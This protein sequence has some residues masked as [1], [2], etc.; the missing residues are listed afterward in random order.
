[1]RLRVFSVFIEVPSIGLCRIDSIIIIELH[2]VWPVCNLC[3][4]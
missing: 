3:K 2:R 1:M 4:K